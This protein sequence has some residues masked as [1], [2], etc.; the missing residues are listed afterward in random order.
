MAPLNTACSENVAPAS[1]SVLLFEILAVGALFALAVWS[2]RPLL[3]EWGLFLAFNVHGLHYFAQLSEL[4]PIRPLHILPYWLQW[5]AAGGRPIGVGILCGLLM[6]LR[7]LV[8]RWA[9]TPILPG[10]QRAAFA[11]LCAVCLGWQGLWFGRFS[12]AQI[13]SILFFATLGF[14]IRLCIRPRISAVVAAGF[15]VLLFLPIYQAPLL[16]TALLPFLALFGCWADASRNPPL[17]RFLLVGVP[18]LAGVLVYVGYSVA[19]YLLVGGAYESNL[20]TLELTPAG[21]LRN[22]VQAYRSSFIATPFTLP[23]YGLVLCLFSAF[24]ARRSPAPLRRL[25]L[26]SLLVTALPFLS[27]IYL[28]PPHTNDPERMLFPVQ[29]GFSLIALAALSGRPGAASQPADCTIL[30]FAL[31]LLVWAAICA[32]EARNYWNLQSYVL[33]TTANLAETKQTTS[34]LIVDR[35]G[36]LG[37]VY[38]FYATTLSE[39][40]TAQGKPLDVVICTP[41]DVDRLHPVARRFPIPTTS[42]CGSDSAGRTV[43]VAEEIG[44]RVHLSA[45]D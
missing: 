24:T 45:K 26:L 15:C 30:M 21:L 43:L 32:V 39:A 8:V 33:G 18:L 27:L 5:V 34:I 31:P 10:P 17:R 3:E 1:R 40:S 23:F 37:D 14:T 25:L 38:T 9:V 36:S 11:L 12:A 44:G 35:T 19:A 22:V 16:V 20:L 29:L 2:I 13:S 6:V 41:V 28:Y 4:S 7:Y 42:R